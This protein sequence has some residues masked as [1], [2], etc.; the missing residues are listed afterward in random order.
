MFELE[1][2]KQDVIVVAHQ[3][4]L[5]CLYAYFT[6]LPLEDCPFVQIPLHTMYV[7]RFPSPYHGLL[8]DFPPSAT[9]KARLT[10]P[11]GRF[12]S[13]NFYI[14][15]QPPLTS[16]PFILLHSIQLTPKTYFCEQEKIKLITDKAYDFVE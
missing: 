3:A 6:D 9:P 16:S 1:R 11:G 13:P 10:T 7:I 4:V 5:R 2:Q 15:L 14:A 8:D 12:R